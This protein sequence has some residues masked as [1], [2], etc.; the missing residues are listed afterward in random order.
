MT[1]GSLRQ[2]IGLVA[3]LMLAALAAMALVLSVGLQR[4]DGLLDR[5]SRSQNQIAQITRIEADIN[6]MLAAAASGRR[7]DS[8]LAASATRIETEFRDYRVSIGAEGEL[9]GKGAAARQ[10]DEARAAEALRKVFSS[11]AVDLLDS[12]PGFRLAARTRIEAGRDLFAELAGDV[13][14]RENQ[15]VT[16]AFADMKRLRGGFTW[17]ALSIPLVVGLIGAA[18]AWFMLTRVAKPLRDLEAAAERAGRGASPSRLKVQGFSEFRSLARA[19]NRMSEWMGARD[20]GLTLGALT[21]DL[22]AREARLGGVALGLPRREF[23][24]LRRLAETP[25]ADVA[26]HDLLDRVWGEEADVTDNLVDVYVG[27]LRRRLARHAGAPR[28]ETVRGVGF[29]IVEA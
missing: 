10:A 28:I 18:A 20:S 11:L 23:E 22:R 19:F 6:G 1:T 16:E 12:D 9:V 8:E 7:T 21:L 5:L 14:S 24:V 17:L 3:V 26:R 29:R 25:G 27:Y 2:A 15:E 13:V 4:A